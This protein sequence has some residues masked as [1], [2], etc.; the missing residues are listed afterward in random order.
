[1]SLIVIYV[2]DSI[3]SKKK[4]FTIMYGILLKLKKKITIFEYIKIR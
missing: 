3:K 2:W 1:M 4:I